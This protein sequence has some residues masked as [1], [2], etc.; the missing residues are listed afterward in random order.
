MRL[1]PFSKIRCKGP[2]AIVDE[3]H[4]SFRKAAT[5][6]SMTGERCSA[7]FPNSCELV[8]FWRKVLTVHPIA[9]N[10]RL[11]SKDRPA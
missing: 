5:N 9:W 1:N 8:F 6:L 11:D 4:N 2:H 3:F 10:S 7:H